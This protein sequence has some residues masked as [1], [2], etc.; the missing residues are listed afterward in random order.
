MTTITSEIRQAIKHA[1]ERPVE[2]TDPETNSIYFLVSAEV[3][4]VC[5]ASTLKNASFAAGSVSSPAT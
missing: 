2:L 3:Y 5:P 4:R 1:G